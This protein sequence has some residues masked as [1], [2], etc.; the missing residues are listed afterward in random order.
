[1]VTKSFAE[2]QQLLDN[3]V[4]SFREIEEILPQRAEKRKGLAFDARVG[5]KAEKE[6][7]AAFDA[8]TRRLEIELESAEGVFSGLAKY[9]DMARKVEETLPNLKAQLSETRAEYSE[10]ANRVKSIDQN[11]RR[12]VIAIRD[13]LETFERLKKNG[14]I[15]DFNLYTAIHKGLYFAFEQNG[16]EPRGLLGNGYYYGGC[17]LPA[18]GEVSSILEQISAKIAQTENRIAQIKADAISFGYEDKELEQ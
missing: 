17:K 2:W 13:A 6:K 16:Q 8:E 15:K 3:E 1:M 4:R 9:R 12:L 7:L 5:G 18:E 14:L 11:A 10:L